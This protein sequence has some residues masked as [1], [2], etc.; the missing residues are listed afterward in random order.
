MGRKQVEEGIARAAMVMCLAIVLLSF[1]GILAAVMIKGLPAM[2][3]A[4]VS[5]TSRGGFYLGS[6]GG[7]L[8]AMVGSLLLAGCA[9]LLSLLVGV[10][11]VVYLN[12][13]ALPGGR[14]VRVA[15]F[16]LDALNGIPSI[17]YGAFG[18]NLMIFLG[19]RASLLGGILTLALLILPV[20]VRLIDEVVA[21]TPVHL[22]EAAF[23]L[24]ATRA[25]T[26][27]KVLLRQSVPGIV[28]AVLFSFGRAIGDAASVIFTAGYSDRIPTSLSEP[29][30]SLPL[31]IF[32]LLSS[33]LP[34]VRIKAYAAALVLTA[35]VLLASILSR[36][37]GRRLGRHVVH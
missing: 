30:A 14:T 12:L 9:T 31:A 8:N 1:A 34:G 33:P 18:F 21:T 16:S 32:F 15:R 4:M 6:S 28:T 7:I 5:E 11:I 20:M 36:L 26:A 13:Y 27:F 29:V 3:W 22:R 35:I 17:V 23:S 37:F 24:G 10:S 2:S 25:Q 19:V